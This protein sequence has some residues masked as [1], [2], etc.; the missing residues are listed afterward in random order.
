MTSNHANLQRAVLIAGFW[1]SAIPAWAA[2]VAGVS[3]PPTE[4]VEGTQ[5]QLAGCAV[6]EQLWTNIY[7]VSFY[8]PRESASVASMINSQT[9]KLIRLDVTY[10]GQVP[11]GLPAEWKAPL[12][13]QVSREF[14]QTLQG[15]YNDLRSGDTV[16]V[17]YVPGSGTTLSVNGNTVVTRPGDDVMNAMMKLWVGPDPVSE[18]M[19]RLLLQGSC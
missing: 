4:T 15:Y 8:L 10:D 12:Q 3:L 2:Q 17:S 13:Q 9:P 18:N 5:L 1:F 16:R 6:R 19:K 11:N 14:V 7:A